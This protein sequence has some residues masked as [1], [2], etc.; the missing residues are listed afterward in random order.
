MTGGMLGVVA[1]TF[2]AGCDWSGGSGA[3]TWDDSNNWVD[4]SGTYRPQE[5]QVLVKAFGATNTP[6]S[7]NYSTNIVSGEV[8]AKAN[9]SDTAYSGYIEQ[10]AIRGSLTIF[11]IGGYRF[12]DSSSAGGDTVS[13]SVTPND[14]SSGT[15]NYSTRAWAL[16]FPAPLASGTEIQASYSWREE[17]A[18]SGSTIDDSGA[19]GTPIYSFVVYQTGNKLKM[20]DSSGSVYEGSLGSVRTTGGTPTDLDPTKALTLPSVSG[21]VVAQFSVTG[22]SQ[23]YKVTIVGTFNG[24]LEGDTFK[25]TSRTMEATFIED[26]GYEG[27][28]KAKAS[29]SET[30]A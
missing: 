21:P 22:V 26:N 25:F 4:F 30:G 10:T 14:G 19:H 13:L 29:D 23:G 12:T 7:T 15:Y 5:G 6:G 2:F 17:H 9:G 11:T 28:I 27:N 1:I 24:Y 18:T 3:D 8:L 20:V 16:K